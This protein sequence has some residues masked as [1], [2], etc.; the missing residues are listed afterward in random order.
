MILTLPTKLSLATLLAA[1]FGLGKSSE[2]S[3]KCR[4]RDNLSR[5]GALQH[6]AAGTAT[7][8]RTVRDASNTGELRTAI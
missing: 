4:L 8:C 6:A 7:N 2:V 1:S 3:P 5:R